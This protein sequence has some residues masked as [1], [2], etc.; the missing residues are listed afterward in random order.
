MGAEPALSMMVGAVKPLALFSNHSV[1]VPSARRQTTSATPLAS[2][3]P[4][5]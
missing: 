5:A 2:K 1:S 4:A 3:S